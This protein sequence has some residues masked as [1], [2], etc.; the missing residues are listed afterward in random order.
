ML[1]KR[2][3]LPTATR[4][5]FCEEEIAEFKA[6]PPGEELGFLWAAPAAVWLPPGPVQRW[7]GSVEETEEERARRCLSL[8]VIKKKKR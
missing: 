2:F 8:V 5:C 3:G 4:A 6:I 1:Q 7:T